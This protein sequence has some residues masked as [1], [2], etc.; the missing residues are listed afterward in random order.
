MYFI[1]Y[2]RLMCLP[3]SH[4]R[5]RR[6]VRQK[7]KGVRVAHLD[8]GRG[9]RWNQWGSRRFQILIE[10]GWSFISGFVFPVLLFGYLAPSFGLLLGFFAS[11]LLG[12]SASLLVRFLLLCFCFP[13]SPCFSAFLLYWFYCVFLLFWSFVSLLLCFPV[14]LLLCFSA[15][16][17]P[18]CFFSC[19][20]LLFG[21]SSFSVYLLFCFLLFLVFLSL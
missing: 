11:L 16:P 10:N 21:F 3:Y 18:L 6:V 12:F 19:L 17:L 13:A 1:T 4:L 8:E 14:S 15:F 9:L 20:F 7:W 2:W 5:F